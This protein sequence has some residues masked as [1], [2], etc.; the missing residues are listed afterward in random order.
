[1]N[2]LITLLFVLS[3]SYSLGQEAPGQEEGLSAESLAEANNPLADMVAFNVQNYYYAKLSETP[4]GTYSNTF[5]FRYAQPIGPVLIRASM[6]IQTSPGFDSIE[7]P[8]GETRAGTGDFN[9]F[10]AWTFISKPTLTVGA[11]PLFVFPTASRQQLGSSQYQAGAAVIVYASSPKVSG[12]GLITYQHSYATKKGAGP[13]PASSLMVAQPF[14]FVQLGKGVYTG[15]A[16][17]W[18]F[19]FANGTN[20]IPLGIRLGKVAKA[21]NTVF[22][23]FAE[24]QFTV[25]HTGANQPVVQF[26]VALNMQFMGGGKKKPN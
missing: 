9:I 12:G 21:G 11:G 13:L 24:P 19:D 6:P 15:G 17:L 5:W 20:H 1:M 25:F 18:I 3:F 2:R 8:N 16:P 26:F 10:G 14:L 22:N 4:P 7:N 23:F